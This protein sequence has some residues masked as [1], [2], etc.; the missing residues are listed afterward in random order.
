M[1]NTLTRNDR[2]N[3][4]RRLNRRVANAL[5]LAGSDYSWREGTRPVGGAPA[6]P[7]KTYGNARNGLRVLVWETQG[8]ICAAC[9]QAVALVDMDVA[10][11]VGN[12][13]A[14]SKNGGYIAGNV[15][16][17][18]PHC[19]DDDAKRFG[20]V[21]P[22]A[23]LVRPDLVPLHYWSRGDMLAADKTYAARVSAAGASE[24]EARWQVRKA[25][26]AEFG[27]L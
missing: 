2:R 22:P 4:I 10:H 13:G 21:V 18:H 5:P 23:S 27:A 16:G 6:G 3:A 12:G 14:P 17:A 1:S 26:L 7:N 11:I 8:G 19:N 20:A 15:Y 25:L 9:G 24:R